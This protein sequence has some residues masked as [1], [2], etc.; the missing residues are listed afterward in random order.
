M[1]ATVAKTFSPFMESMQIIGIQWFWLEG[2]KE[3]HE[4]K[5]VVGEMCEVK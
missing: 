3:C 2:V 5:V 1:R 4:R